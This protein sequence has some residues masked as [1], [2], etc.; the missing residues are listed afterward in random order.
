VWVVGCSGPINGRKGTVTVEEVTSLRVRFFI[1]WTDF[2]LI[3]PMTPLV[4]IL[5]RPVFP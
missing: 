3:L 2:P 4:R 5:R 1:L